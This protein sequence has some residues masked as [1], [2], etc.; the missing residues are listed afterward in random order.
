MSWKKSG[1]QGT[2]LNTIKSVHSKP[3]ANIK[4]NGEKC[5]AMPLKLGAW[6][7][8][9]LSP[10]LITIVLLSFTQSNKIIEGDQR[11]INGKGRSQSI[12][13]CRWYDGIYKWP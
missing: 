2:Y 9:L 6:Q 4:V 11:D 7:G 12:F 10:S 13:I 8:C 1:I 5:K 3:I